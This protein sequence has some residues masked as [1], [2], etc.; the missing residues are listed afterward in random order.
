MVEREVLIDCFTVVGN[1][2]AH[3]AREHDLAY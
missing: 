2:A 1:K 3:G